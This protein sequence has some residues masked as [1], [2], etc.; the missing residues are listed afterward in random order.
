MLHSRHYA[1]Q[2]Q[3][4]HMPVIRLCR[5]S[6]VKYYSEEHFESSQMCRSTAKSWL[7]VDLHAL[8]EP[9]SAIQVVTR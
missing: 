3:M 9:D 8:A 2:S 1:H 4:I 5:Y 7:Q 6:V